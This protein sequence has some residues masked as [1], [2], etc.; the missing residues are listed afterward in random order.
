ML[1]RLLRDAA[2]PDAA[3]HLDVQGREA[4]AQVCSLA[5]RAGL[6]LLAA[7]AGLHAQQQH[8]RAGAA[9]GTAQPYGRVG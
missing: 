6:E 8:L 5:E 4:R 3:V 9:S 7:K 1:G 2:G